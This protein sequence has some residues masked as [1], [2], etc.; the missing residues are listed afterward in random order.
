MLE[1]KNSQTHTLPEPKDL[2]WRILTISV[3]GADFWMKSEKIG[4][5]VARKN[6]IEDSFDE[7]KKLLEEEIPLGN[8]VY[9]DENSI[10]FL[11]FEKFSKEL[12][13][14]ENKTI[15]ERIFDVFKEKTNGELRPHIQPSEPSRGAVTLGELLKEIKKFNEP[16]E[17][18]IGKYWTEV[19]PRSNNAGE[20]EIC[21]VCGL[22]A[23]GVPQNRE[24]EKAQKRHICTVCLGRRKNRSGIWTEESKKRKDTIWVD[25]VSDPNNRIAL[26]VGKFDLENWIDSTYL[27]TMFTKTLPDL[28]NSNEKRVAGLSGYPD[29]IEAASQSFTKEIIEIGQITIDR[30]DF[31][32]S[33]GKESYHEQ[34]IDDYFNALILDRERERLERE[35]GN[36]GN[37]DTEIK[38]S[39]LISFLFRKNPSFARTRRIWETALNFWEDVDEKIGNVLPE[40]PRYEITFKESMDFSTSHTYYLRVSGCLVPTVANEKNKMLIVEKEAKLPELLKKYIRKE[41]LDEKIEILESDKKTSI[42]K[43]KV[44][45]VEKHST[46]IPYINILKEP[47]VFISLVPAEKA[48]KAVRLIKE[49]Y[50]IEFSKV[51]N[52]LP[53]NVC[54]VFMNKKMPLYIALNSARRFL[55][56]KNR[57]ECWKVLGVCDILGKGSIEKRKLILKKEDIVETEMDFLLGNGEVDYY[58]PYFIIERGSCID[59]RNT[60]FETYG[61]EKLI[62]VTDL[63]KG[64]IVEYVPSFFDFVFLDSNARRFDISTENRKRP[65]SIFT[66][67]P[68]PYYL[69]DV[70]KF[71][72]V[73]ETLEKKM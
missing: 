17:E 57:S 45:K 73:W 10:A 48:L 27:N 24:S 67:G 34:P 8:E 11:L 5:I 59:K 1:H 29:L 65:H 26:I 18:D 51:K 63:V 16:F 41:Q 58:H 37:W 28:H 71:R 20:I 46:Y 60:Y 36:S 52:R 50:E 72:E 14:S 35:L 53:M 44:E 32:K 6:L 33:I 49:K 2:K 4:D 56:F 61:K 9:R 68:R 3:N 31:L 12:R 25:E 69:E 21:R 30:K 39:L 23:V 64:D 7:I 43:G 19:K 15:E 38:A 13:I 47:S 55:E 22:R 54:L 70:D 62:H 66:S 40:D 42:G